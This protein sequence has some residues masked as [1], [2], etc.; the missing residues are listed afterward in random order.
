MKVLPAKFSTPTEWPSRHGRTRKTGGTSRPNIQFGLK[1]QGWRHVSYVTYDRN[2]RVVRS[3]GTNMVTTLEERW[4]QIQTV[5]ILPYIEP[6]VCGMDSEKIC[7]DS[8]QQ[9][10]L[11]VAWNA[12][13]IVEPWVQSTD[14]S[15]GMCESEEEPACATHPH[16]C[17]CD[18]SKIYIW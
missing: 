7:K 9:L 12:N 15:L 17:V 3:G 14:V 10:I 5:A 1:R 2:C 16:V 8:C 6:C 11:H 18:T 4:Q 13:I